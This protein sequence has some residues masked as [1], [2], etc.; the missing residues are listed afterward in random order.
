MVLYILCKL[1]FVGDL[2]YVWVVLDFVC[3]VLDMF[4]YNCDFDDSL[5]LVVGV[6]VCWLEGKGIVV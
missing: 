6:L 3:L 5:V 2:L 1:F 4:V